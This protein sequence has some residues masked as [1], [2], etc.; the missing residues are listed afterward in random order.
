MRWRRAIKAG[1]IAEGAHPAAGV[2]GAAREVAQAWAPDSSSLP[3]SRETLGEPFGRP[4]VWPE[5]L[6]QG[7]AL[8][9]ALRDRRASCQAGYGSISSFSANEPS[10]VYTLA[11]T[12]TRLA[13]SILSTFTFR[14]S[15]TQFTSRMA[16]LIGADHRSCGIVGRWPL[17]YAV[18]GGAT[19][20]K[21]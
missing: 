1:S 13:V 16:S 19:S 12:L 10:V 21:P 4:S 2:E 5:N 3:S 8:A 9:G 14:T 15:V 17:I 18:A 7:D 11:V 6:A 20:R